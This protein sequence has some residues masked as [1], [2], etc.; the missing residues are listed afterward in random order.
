MKTNNSLWVCTWV[1]ACGMPHSHFS[2]HRILQ[3]RKLSSQ[4]VREEPSLFM[5]P[6]LFVC[7][8]PSFPHMEKGRTF[9][10][11]SNSVNL[12][13]QGTGMHL[14]MLFFQLVTLTRP[15]LWSLKHCK[16]IGALQSPTSLVRSIEYKGKQIQLYDFRQ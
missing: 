9:F 2:S 11:I 15:L 4:I 8:L 3:S 12:A 14:K 7:H 1:L 5:F 13:I 10:S 16:K 6:A